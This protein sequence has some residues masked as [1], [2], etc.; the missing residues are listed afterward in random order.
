[1]LAWRGSFIKQNVGSAHRPSNRVS[2]QGPMRNSGS[3][4][5]R[6][7]VPAIDA[8]ARVLAHL[9]EGEG[10]G[11]SDIGRAC[12]LSKSSAHAIVKALEAARLLV[13]LG[14]TKRYVLGAGLV[15]LGE[16][17]GRQ[18]T[19]VLLARP[20]LEEVAR[21]LR[22][23]CFLVVPYT[24]SEFLLVEKAE[25]SRAIK[26]TVSVGERFP[27]TAGSLGKAYL[28]WQPADVV[29]GALR[30]APLTGRAGQVLR[31]RVAY[32]AE[33][34]TV[35]R[36]GFAESYEEHYV[37]N[38]ALAAPVFDHSGRVVLLLLTVGF[39]A[40][41]PAA[42]MKRYGRLLRAAADRVTRAF[43]GRR[44]PP[45]SPGRDGARPPAARRL[46]GRFRRRVTGDALREKIPYAR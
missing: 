15:E 45:P 4:R 46:P 9:A 35:R 36:Q 25:S 7:R 6:S 33:L 17:A 21:R 16:A 31:S 19:A 28:A 14:D 20:H 1:M 40:A 41:M 23:A 42:R 22:L 34:A 3:D 38:N 10:A 44:P 11:V 37:G 2:K 24:A 5:E 32:L 27:L 29:R 8:A 13:P 26:V 39:S 12:H 43:G 30:A 18:R